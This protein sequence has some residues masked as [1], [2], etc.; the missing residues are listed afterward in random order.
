MPIQCM[1]WN[2]K[3]AFNS[4]FM[5]RLTVLNEAN[6]T[7]ERHHSDA[8]NEHIENIENVRVWDVRHEIR[9]RTYHLLAISRCNSIKL[10]A[11]LSAIMHRFQV[12]LSNI[13]LN[14]H[15]FTMITD[16]TYS[17]NYIRWWAALMAVPWTN[18]SRMEIFKTANITLEVIVSNDSTFH[19]DDIICWYRSNQIIKNFIVDFYFSFHFG[20]SNNF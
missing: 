14:W 4:T 5:A 10:Q 2:D 8:Y 17:L 6:V 18:T 20:N 16:T 9:T 15:H 3:N 19:F 13:H 12:M 11:P 7:F 1:K